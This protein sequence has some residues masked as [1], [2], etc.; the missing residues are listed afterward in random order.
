MEKIKLFFKKDSSVLRD[1]IV[2]F[3]VLSL[4]IYKVFFQNDHRIYSLLFGSIL[5][6]GVLVYIVISAGR[7]FKR[8]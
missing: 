6:I 1:A 3:I 2:A 8:Q 7:I 5:I 4:G